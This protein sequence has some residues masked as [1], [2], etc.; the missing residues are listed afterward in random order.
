MKGQPTE[1]E[2]IFASYSLEEGL[3]SRIYKQLNQHSSFHPDWFGF[4]CCFS[5]L[6]IF[7]LNFLFNPNTD[8]QEQIVG[9][10]VLSQTRQRKCI[11]KGPEAFIIIYIY[12][13]SGAL[14]KQAWLEQETNRIF[15]LRVGSV[16]KSF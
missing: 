1:W 7:F 9:V 11:C 10:S 12:I 2:K 16:L 6:L 5:L 13:K 4:Y 15:V 3:I 8:K 14:R